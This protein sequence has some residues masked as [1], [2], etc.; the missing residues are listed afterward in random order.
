MT[1]LGTESSSKYWNSFLQ[2]I[3]RLRAPDGCP[4]DKEQTNRSIAPFAIEES[5]ELAEAIERGDDLEIIDELGDVLLQVVLHSQIASETGRFTIENVVAAISEKII[6]RHPHVFQTNEAE[7]K[8]TTSDQVLTRWQEIKKAE[9]SKSEKSAAT[10]SKFRFDIPLA[11]PALLRSA[12]IGDKTSG[13]RFDWP[14]WQDVLLKVEEELNE[15][16][17]A[18]KESKEQTFIAKDHPET[19]TSRDPVACEIGDLLFSVAQLARHRGLDPEQCL[20]EANA[21]FER[22]YGLLRKIEQERAA[23]DGRNWESRAQDEIESL[24]REAKVAELKGE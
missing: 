10:G 1:E 13:L 14:N 12:K 5:F 11:L 23:N 16:K 4:W 18:L 20:R 3:A 22:R 21:R 9:K 2:I 7:A 6:R 24:W 19:G 17:A 8:L 15:V